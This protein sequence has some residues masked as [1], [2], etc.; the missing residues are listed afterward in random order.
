MQLKYFFFI[1]MTG[2]IILT[3]S[4]SCKADKTYQCVSYVL[5]LTLMAPEQAK[6]GDAQRQT[7]HVPFIKATSTKIFNLQAYE[8]PATC[9][10]RA[11]FSKNV[12]YY[13]L[14]VYDL[15]SKK[16]TH[17]YHGK[18]GSN[19]VSFSEHLKETL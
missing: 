6:K 12:S 1:L 17:Q 14:W 16:T 5:P 19:E 10:Q 4:T 7:E 9:K 18:C 15:D 11:C 13:A 8:P 2:I 3:H